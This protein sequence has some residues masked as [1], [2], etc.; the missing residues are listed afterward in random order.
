MKNVILVSVF[1]LSIVACNKKEYV[2]NEKMADNSAITT[3]AENGTLE[4]LVDQYLAMKNALVNAD[5]AKTA[6]LGKAILDNS[7][8]LFNNPNNKDVAEIL[9]DIQENAEHIS[10][11]ADKM[12]HLRK[13]FEFLSKDFE[14]LVAVHPYSKTLY[15]DFCTMAN[16]NKGAYWLSEYKE[17]SN[18][19]QD[20]SMRT[21][22]EVKQEIAGK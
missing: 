8:V 13:H 16:D 22:G 15:K 7:K 11:N 6:E 1:L 2:K 17:I 3:N 21:C 9:S 12:E 20:E 14:D 10:E 19:Y 5:G 4:G 18:P